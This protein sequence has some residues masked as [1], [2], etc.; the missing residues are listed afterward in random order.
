MKLKLN[1]KKIFL[2]LYIFV[3]IYQPN[4]SYLLKINSFV[5]YG[6]FT[7][8]Y[9]LRYICTKKR[10]FFKQY[11]K[12][13]IF[14]FI[15]LTFFSSIYYIIRSAIAM[16]NFFDISE[17]RIIQ[18]FMPIMYLTS[19]LIVNY[20]L[21]ELHYNFSN[22]I[23]FI[24]NIGLFQSFIVLS[25]YIFPILK[26][27]ANSIYCSTGTS[28]NYFI[29]T[30]RIYGICNGDYTYG[31]QLLHALLAITSVA[32]AYFENNKKYY[33]YSM[34]LLVPAISNG[35]FSIIVFVVSLF[36]FFTLVMLKKQ[37]FLKN[38]KFFMTI[39]L[40]FSVGITVVI[41]YFPN[42]IS[43][44]NH[45]ISDFNNYQEGISNT[46]SSIFSEMF[47]FP[48]FTNMIFGMGYRVY[49][50]LSYKYEFYKLSDIGF[51]NDIFMGG[52]VYIMLIYNS[53]LI[54]LSSVIK[55]HENYSLENILSKEILIFIILANIKGEF[56]RNIILQA[57][58][59]LFIAIL[60]NYKGVKKN[61]KSKI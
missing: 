21:N 20:E 39:F 13:E 59:M 17:L 47:F 14:I 5:M 6:L 18:S 31:F 48:S 23:K 11:I 56:F 8:V 36:L 4:L 19:G 54:L 45:A 22:K 27:I 53:Y 52:I 29:I 38:L 35:R 3:I 1:F 25:M 2:A 60:C 41:N 46:E 42:V 49:G 9:L 37:S 7:L 33:I 58:V 32:Y 55:K 12:K 57:S 43:I 26:E 34:L 30:Y 10:F 51:V 16:K 28:C 50:G 15:V 61:E 24:L 40:L 44:V